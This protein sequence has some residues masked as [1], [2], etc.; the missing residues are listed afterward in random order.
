[1]PVAISGLL[2]I[3]DAEN[4]LMSLFTRE[5]RYKAIKPSQ[6]ESLLTLLTLGY[7]CPL[8]VYLERHSL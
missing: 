6:L 3:K 8:D 4:H 1:M 5:S 7:P 2:L